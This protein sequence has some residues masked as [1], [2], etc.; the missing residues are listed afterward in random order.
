VG[1]LARALRVGVGAAVVGTWVTASRGRSARGGDTRAVY[2]G[3][4]MGLL[5]CAR[6]RAM[7]EI[8][9]TNSSERGPHRHDSSERGP[10]GAGVG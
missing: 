1:G 10:K 5:P 2:E 6:G 9:E 4:S 7:F 3:E 8:V